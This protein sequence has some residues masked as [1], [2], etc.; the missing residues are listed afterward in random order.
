MEIIRPAFCKI[1][2]KNLLHNYKILKHKLKPKTQLLTVVKANAYGHGSY[3]IANSLEKY[4]LDKLIFGVATI[5]EGIYL[6]TKGIK[7]Q[8]LVLGSIYPFSSFD[9]IINYNLTPTISSLQIARK[10]SI[11]CK[12]LDINLNVHIKV[13]TGMGRIGMAVKRASGFIEK[14]SF[15]PGLKIEGVYTHISSADKDAEFTQK[16]IASFSN[17]KSDLKKKGVSVKYFHAA[18]TE[19]LFGYKN[20]EFNMV[21]AGISLYGLFFPRD[22]NKKFKPVLELKSKIVFLKTVPDGT[23][24]SYGGT[25]V[26]T[27]KTVVATI[28]IGYADGYRRAWSNQIDGIVRGQK[29]RQIGRICM[30]MCMFDVT[31][32]ANVKIGDDI[33]LVGGS[34]EQSIKIEDLAKKAETIPYEIVTQFTSRLPRIIS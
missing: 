31:D 16:Q 32:V 21:R 22:F 2:V 28:P 1:H 3:E 6:R 29:V 23:P 10:I 8:I 19:T 5:E 9:Y 27:R 24:I 25:F 4:I 7:S 17:L 13:D 33:I 18:N 15:L 30:D 12:K 34:S 20:A 26:T 11:F 14:I